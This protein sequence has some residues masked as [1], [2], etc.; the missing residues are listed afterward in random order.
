MPV[1]INS[2]FEKKCT[3]CGQRSKFIIVL[4]PLKGYGFSA[5]ISPTPY[6][7]GCF[8]AKTLAT[9]LTV[10][11]YVV[12]ANIYAIAISN[13]QT[14]SETHQNHPGTVFLSGRRVMG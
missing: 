9:V 10:T 14:C 4:S 11:V 12:S 6:A 8:K 1:Y 7:S 13:P 3:I 2:N 5:I